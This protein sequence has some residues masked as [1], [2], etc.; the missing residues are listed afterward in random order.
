MDVVNSKSLSE[1]FTLIELIIVMVVMLVIAA[2]SYSSRGPSSSININAQADLMA[3]DIR[4]TQMLSMTRGER[5]RLKYFTNS[6]QILNSSNLPILMPSGRT[7]T[8]LVQGISLSGSLPNNLIVFDTNGVP[9]T[10]NPPETALFGV[11]PATI[12]LTSV[13]GLTRIISIY[14]GTGQVK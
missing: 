3:S 13:D 1:G 14:P 7:L 12:T 9:Y 11:N 10:Y 4:Y 8:K 2:V 6:Y 5:Y